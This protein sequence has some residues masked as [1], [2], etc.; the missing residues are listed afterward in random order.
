MTRPQHDY[1]H[2]FNNPENILDTLRRAHISIEIVGQELRLSH[3]VPPD[4]MNV[5]QASRTKLVK[6]LE[7]ERG[8]L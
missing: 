1:N 6:L 7:K 5:I 4:I 3:P 8:K 2:F